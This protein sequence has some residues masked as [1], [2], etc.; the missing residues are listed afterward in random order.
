MMRQVTGV[1]GRLSRNQARSEWRAYR[2]EGIPVRGEF[3]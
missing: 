1:G 2:E 3:K